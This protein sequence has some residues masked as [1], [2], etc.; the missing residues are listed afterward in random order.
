[1]TI[2]PSADPNLV[3]VLYL[4]EDLP[5]ASFLQKVL[6]ASSNSL[7]EGRANFARLLQQTDEED[8][9]ALDLMDFEFSLLD[10]L[11]Y[12]RMRIP[13]RSIR[14][15]HVKCF[16]LEN[17]MEL[18]PEKA[19]R[20]C[21]VCG[22]AVKLQ[23]LRQD[24]FVK[25][26]LQQTNDDEDEVKM[27][28]N[29]EW[30]HCERE[31]NIEDLDD[32]EEEEEEEE[33]DEDDRE[34]EEEHNRDK[35]EELQVQ[36]GNVFATTGIPEIPPVVVMDS[37]NGIPGSLFYPNNLNTFG[38][39]FEQA[40]QSVGP[41]SISMTRRLYPD[42]S[43][44]LDAAMAFDNNEIID[45]VSCSSVEDEPDE[46]TNNNNFSNNSTSMYNTNCDPNLGSQI[47]IIDISD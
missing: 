19:N 33:Y 21:P 6:E 27:T 47:E 5:P 14:C 34:E 1:M 40:I 9:I 24:P 32:M 30:K 16:D 25:S 23:D 36:G 13:V 44:L 29:G 10:P 41:E 37:Q 3:S 15:S 11:S 38:Q 31:E 39:P 45:L 20:S 43:S 7:E 28:M 2:S 17:F 26:I 4:C 42:F 22:S 8:D 18:Y 12:Q 46:N 35:H